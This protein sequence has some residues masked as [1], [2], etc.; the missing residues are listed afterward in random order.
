M[1][2]QIE[3]AGLAGA[4]S[5]ASSTVHATGGSTRCPRAP[6]RPCRR[7]RRASAATTVTRRIWSVLV[8]VPSAESQRRRTRAGCG[9]L[10]QVVHG[11]VPA[12]RSPTS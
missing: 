8:M 11:R 1:G 12:G 2:V 7:C 10:G 6:C 9:P 3:K 4:M 5:V